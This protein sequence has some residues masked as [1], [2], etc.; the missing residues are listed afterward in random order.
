MD[1]IDRLNGE[2]YVD[3]IDDAITEIGELRTTRAAIARILE[4]L[5][6]TNEV[7]RREL[8]KANDTNLAL[9]YALE[10]ARA[11]VAKAHADGVQTV[12]SP[13]CALGRIDAALEKV[14]KLA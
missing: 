6:D 9:V 14:G 8:D 12:L 7:L 5:C 10:L 2:N 13:K 1:I 3:A 11:Y 4:Q